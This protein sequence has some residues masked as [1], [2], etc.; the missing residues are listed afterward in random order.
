[1]I[2]HLVPA[3]LVAAL[4]AGCG[5]STDKTS[6]RVPLLDGGRKA[7]EQ[8]LAELVGTPVVVNQWASWCGPCRLEFPIFSAVANRLDGQVAFL[9]VDAKDSRE[10]AEQ[11]LAESPVPYDNYYDPDL[12]IA[13]TFR[14]GRAWPTTAFYTRDGELAYTH[15]GPYTTEA[16]LEAAI[17]E[18]ALDG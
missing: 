2:R 15:Y 11:F 7:F 5:D 14:G 6:V 1:M 8:R 12:E 9:G 10:D 17:R 16:E 18:Y 3:V 4:M 13:R